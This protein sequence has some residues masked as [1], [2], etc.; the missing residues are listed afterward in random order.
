MNRFDRFADWCADTIGST[1]FFLFALVTVVVWLFSYPLFKSFDTWQL[2]ISAVLN[3]L[4][5]LAL[6]LLHNTQH[7]F[8]LATNKRLLAIE[9]QGHGLQDQVEDEGQR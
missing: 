8:E 4:S 5:W 2:V 6:V 3:I 7:R 1:K 9:E